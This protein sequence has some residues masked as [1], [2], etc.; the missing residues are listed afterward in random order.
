VSGL[1]LQVSLKDTD[2]HNRVKT[3]TVFSFKNVEN[4]SISAD[5]KMGI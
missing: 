5:V 2:K 4:A 3:I 1:K